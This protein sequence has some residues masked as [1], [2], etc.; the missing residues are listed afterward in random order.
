MIRV[1]FEALASFDFKFRNNFAC[2][3]TVSRKL[4]EIA[5]NLGGGSKH[6]FERLRSLASS[7]E[8]QPAVPLWW[9]PYDDSSSALSVAHHLRQQ[10]SNIARPAST[11]ALIVR[12]LHHRRRD[13]AFERQL[14]NDGKRHKDIAGIVA[15]ERRE[16]LS[17]RES[18]RCVRAVRLC[19][20]CRASWALAGFN[21]GQ[22]SI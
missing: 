2:T 16:P 17:A 1:S 8:L 3:A 7:G 18:R 11:F 21:L 12:S 9:P 22:G 19:D 15:L 20:D 4:H 13:A 6:T 10:S 5:L 14:A